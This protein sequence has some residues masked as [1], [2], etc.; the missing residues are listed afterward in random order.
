MQTAPTGS[1]ALTCLFRMLLGVAV[2]FVT[3]SVA[4][5]CME[6]TWRSRI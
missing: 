2:A 1:S 6:L 4:G 3:D 5:R